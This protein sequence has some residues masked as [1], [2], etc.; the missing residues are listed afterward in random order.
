MPF[1]ENKMYDEQY[2]VASGGFGTPE[3]FHSEIGMRIRREK[4][5]M[6]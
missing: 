1:I 5:N 3:R 6:Y 2:S 4:A